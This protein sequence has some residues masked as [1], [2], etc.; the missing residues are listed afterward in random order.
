MEW[1]S[2]NVLFADVKGYSSLDDQMMKAFYEKVFPQIGACLR[3]FEI[4]DLNTWG[5]G[6]VIICDK[7]QDICELSLLMRDKFRQINWSRLGLP[8]LDIRI[9]LHHGEYLE[10]IDGVTGR[11]TFCGKSIVSAARLEPITPPGVVWLTDT[12]ARMLRDTGDDFLQADDIGSVTLPKNYGELSIC[13]LRRKAEP[14]LTSEQL[15]CIRDA[16]AIRSGGAES[17]R[18]GS[19]GEQ[20]NGLCILIGVVVSNGKVVLVKRRIAN[21]GLEWM[22]P[23][24]KCLPT[25]SQEYAIEKEIFA[26]TGLHAKF[27]RLICEVPNHPV[28]GKRCKYFVLDAI[29][30][31]NV[32]NSDPFENSAA[33]WVDIEDA[34]N[35]VGSNMNETVKSHLRRFSGRGS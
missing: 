6:I 30:D 19:E 33:E 21:E 1:R 9:S 13:A 23:S 34:I 15:Q 20:A 11:P 35:R 25:D 18:S 14:K 32:R 27:N 10:G 12:A 4:R 5:D 24:G 7:I 26:E 29:G 17:L 31:L 3:D 22:F 28:T 16:E 8:S 2:S